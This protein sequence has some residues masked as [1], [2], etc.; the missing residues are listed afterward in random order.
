MADYSALSRE[1]LIELLQT[2][3]AKS[4]ASELLHARHCADNQRTHVARREGE[5][6][7]RAILDTAVE[8]IITIDERGII[9]SFNAAAETIFGYPATEIIGRNVSAL[10]PSPDR[11]RHD[12]YL[13][14]YM[15]TGHARIIGIGREVVGR[16]KDGSLFP[17]DLSVSEVRLDDRRLFTGFVRDI[18]ERKRLEK[19]VLEI[20]ERERRSVGHTL[21]DGLCQHLAGIELMS[22]VLEQNLS[23]KSKPAAA[24]AG[25]IAENVRQAIAQT[26][27]LAHGLSPV[28]IE[29]EGLASALQ[30]LAD[31]VSKLS[32]VDC[33]FECATSINV[34]DSSMAT[35]LYRIAQ[36]AANN[37]IKH[38]KA[39]NVVI[40]LQRGPHA[41]QLMVV[42]S[43]T[44]FPTRPVNNGGMGLQI[45]KYRAGIIGAT[46]EIGPANGRGTAVVC[47]FRLPTEPSRSAG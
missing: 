22:Q 4:A 13:A 39:K 41:A 14:N 27:M 44:G 31:S 7:L 32:H 5:E 9:E 19:E 12:G 21:H 8:G 45:M 30:E 42:D 33:R 36:E 16:R 35:H 10:M 17:M 15:R 29:S 20:S 24:Q 18:T 23:K 46:L 6:R 26:R 3:E 11:E 2:L 34:C 1:Q 37:A 43:G 25:K 28:T 47:T 38:G 40:R